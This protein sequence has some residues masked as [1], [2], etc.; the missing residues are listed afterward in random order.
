MS[1]RWAE[2]RPVYWLLELVYREVAFNAAGDQA[3]S[4]ESTSLWDADSS[5]TTKGSRLQTTFTYFSEDHAMT[6]DCYA[7]A[8]SWLS[9]SHFERMKTHL[10]MQQHVKDIINRIDGLWA[11]EVSGILEPRNL[12]NIRVSGT[13]EARSRANNVISGISEARN[14]A[15]CVVVRISEAQ[16]KTMQIPWYQAPRRPQPMQIS[17]LRAP[18]RPAT[19]KIA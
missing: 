9:R 3:P 12:S 7:L 18:Q 17:W 6:M 10:T 14:A 11:I 19:M 16:N 15:N 1:Q 8:S 2:I 5:G 4:L 13:L